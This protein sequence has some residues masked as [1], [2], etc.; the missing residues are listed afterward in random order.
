VLT[1]YGAVILGE[2][3]PRFG[4]IRCIVEFACGTA[5]GALWL[6][7]REQWH[8][9]AALAF[10]LAALLLGGW[11]AGPLPETLAVPAA[12]AALLL[13]LALT[14]G[15]PR[16][17]L[18]V[19]PLHYLGEISYATY[20]SH[21]LLWFAFKLAFVSDA[22]AVSWPLIASY[23]ALVL[24]SSAALYHAIERPAQHWLNR[25]SF[26]RARQAPTAGSR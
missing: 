14:A 10:A 24:A 21:F 4:L 12:F 9:P 5:I 8:A 7:W 22:H 20:L 17:P 19:A 16:N 18:E 23:L 13:A 25:L 11:I 1:G 6:R 26:R 3:V 2:Q 15:R